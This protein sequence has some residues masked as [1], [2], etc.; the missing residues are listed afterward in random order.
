MSNETERLAHTVVKAMRLVPTT[1]RAYVLESDPS[2][3]VVKMDPAGTFK[4]K[5]SKA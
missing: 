4:L 1:V 5:V 2:T 3:V